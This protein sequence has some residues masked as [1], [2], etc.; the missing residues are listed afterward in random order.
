MLL[1]LGYCLFFPPLF[2]LVPLAGLLLASRPVSIRE[3]AWILLA[4]L[5]LA[6]SL[7]PGSGLADSAHAAWVLFITAA[8]VALMIGAERRLVAGALLAVVFGFGALTVWAEL[9][10]T[11]WRG[12]E[13][14]VTR[15]GWASLRGLLELARNLVEQKALAGDKLEGIRVGLEGMGEVIAA[16][17]PL[18]PALLILRSLPG[19]GLAWMLYQRLAATPHGEPAG[20]FADFRFSD[21]FVWGVVLMV[22]G[23]LIP[24]PPGLDEIAGNLALVTAGL[25]IARGVAVGWGVI[26]DSPLPI[27]VLV[28]M[29]TLFVLPVVLG[30]CFALGLADTW[31][32]FRRRFAAGS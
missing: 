6:L 4:A 28:A 31:L 21:Q 22:A 20:R 2:V 17:S 19:L 12:I 13:L 23:M 29:G 25:Y 32:D 10:G 14:A 18:L 3:W 26:S 11:S 15:E 1:V 5:W 8:F 30:G 27:L 7:A 16:S 9:L 24:L